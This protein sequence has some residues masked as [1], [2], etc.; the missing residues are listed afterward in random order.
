MEVFLEEPF[1][2]LWEGE[3][4]FDKAFAI[5]G[6][7]YRDMG[8]RHTSRFECNGEA[9]FIKTHAGVGWREICKNLISLRKPVL[10]ARNEWRAIARLKTLGIDTLTAVAFGWRGANPAR[11]QSFIITRALEP[12]EELDSYC[13]ADVL[14]RMG[15]R[16]RRQLVRKLAAIS[17]TMHDSGVN[18]RDFYLCHFLLDISENY[19]NTP[20]HQRPIYL[21]DLHRVQIRE[22]TP[23]RWRHKD[24]AGLYYS[25]RRAGF[26]RRDV[27]CFIERYKEQPLR[28]ALNEGESFWKSI[29]KAADKLHAKG[30]RKGYHD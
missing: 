16:N 9:F 24:L 22:R 21:I 4:P 1:A 23:R 15:P 29:E 11:Q 28:Q 25:A 13:N 5:E 6:E 14:A 19:A 27:L 17:R 7:S 10:G 30:V 18:H 26:S 20:L 2:S 12:T 8:D 3:D